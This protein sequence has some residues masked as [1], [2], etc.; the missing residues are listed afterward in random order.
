MAKK[1]VVKE[2]ELVDGKWA[3]TEKEL[4]STGDDALVLKSLILQSEDETKQVVL[5]L[6]NDGILKIV[7]G[8]EEF[9]TLIV[10]KN[11]QSGEIVFDQ[12][13]TMRV[14]F[15]REFSNW[16]SIS[17]TLAEQNATPPYRIWPGKTGFTIK[18]QTNFTGA[19]S[20]TA[21]EA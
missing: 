4:N 13:K 5:K 7:D 6:D 3:K 8:E 14:D 2:L 20:W 18:F 16:P 19:V 12:S 21:V 11:S 17:L 10:G 9:R 1:Q 15:P